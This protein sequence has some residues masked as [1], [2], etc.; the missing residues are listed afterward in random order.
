MLTNSL[1]KR[2]LQSSWERLNNINKLKCYII[3]EELL[4]KWPKFQFLPNVYLTY[5]NG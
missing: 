2:R 4:N 5:G 3:Y 1:Y